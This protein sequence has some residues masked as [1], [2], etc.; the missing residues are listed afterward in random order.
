MNDF[1]QTVNLKDKLAKPVQPSPAKPTGQQANQSPPKERQINKVFSGESENIYEFQKINR[2]NQPKYN[3]VLIKRILLGLAAVIVIIMIFRLWPN[4]SK[5][6]EEKTAENNKPS[7]ATTEQFEVKWYAI[8]LVNNEIYYGQ[9]GDIKSDPVVVSNVY[10]DY[11]Q[12]NGKATS[13]GDETTGSLRLVKRGKE[14]HG[15]SGTMDIVR[16]QIIFMEP[17][18]D[19]SKVLGAILDYEKK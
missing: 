9:I 4:A 12:A 10:Y 11:D 13:S 14:T 8:K 6:A 16:S 5:K 19:D 18:K 1:N 3:E 17:L 15:P 7:D 2:P